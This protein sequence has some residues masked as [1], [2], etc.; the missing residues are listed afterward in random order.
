MQ[1]MMATWEDIYRQTFLTE[2]FPDYTD[3]EELLNYFI[4]AKDTFSRSV[5]SRN[6]RTVSFS[7]G[8]QVT[9]SWIALSHIPS[10][11]TVDLLQLDS[12]DD[13]DNFGES[14]R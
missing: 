1:F 7:D 9:L 5:V 11:H 4:N 3:S 13:Y 2:L 8:S 14:V 10:L 12:G 6:D